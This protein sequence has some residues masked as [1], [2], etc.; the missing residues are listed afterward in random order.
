MWANARTA[1]LA[2]ARLVHYFPFCSR[3]ADEP[4]VHPHAG[5][6]AP[7][8]PVEGAAGAFLTLECRADW[9]ALCMA[10]SSP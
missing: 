7:A 2:L 10:V 4:G 9:F 1:R 8:V 5:L 3:R 6:P